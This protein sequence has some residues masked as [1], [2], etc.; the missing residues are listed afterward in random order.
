MIENIQLLATQLADKVAKKY[1]VEPIKAKTYIVQYWAKHFDLQTLCSAAP[2]LKSITRTRLYKDAEREVTRKLYYELR[3]YQAEQDV[4][5]LVQALRS[6][7][8][9]ES[10]D[11]A[12]QQLVQNH[13][14]TH[15]RLAHLEEFWQLVCCYVPSQSRILDVGC[16]ILPLVFPFQTAS[17]QE[18][19][20]L[21]RSQD[22]IDTI[23]AFQEAYDIQCLSARQWSIQDGWAGVEP[24]TYD[25]AFLFKLVP[26]VA[27]QEP[28]SLTVLS[29][30]PAKR[31]I[32]T[33]CKKAM[34][35]QRD[36]SRRERTLL[37]HFM[38]SASM[39]LID[40]FETA[41]EIGFV[42][43]PLQ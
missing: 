17:V 3:R 35:K 10:K 21:D 20:A 7:Q 29:Q 24:H 37:Q 27:R 28:S 30:V 32:L 8:T 40:E 12:R 18:Y 14:S 16:G 33:G 19:L 13:V 41:D 23:T 5:Q 42:C 9:L 6:A 22:S 25:V 11:H 1:R 31:L 26:V 43:E 4:D 39:Q 36:I 38:G 2:T 34:V 15:E